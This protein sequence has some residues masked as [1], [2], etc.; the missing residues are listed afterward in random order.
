MAAEEVKADL[1]NWRSH[2]Y[3]E[4]G[5]A[6]VDKILLTETI[7]KASQ[8]SQT[9]EQGSKNLDSFSL[10]TRDGRTLNITGFLVESH[11]DGFMVLH[12][13]K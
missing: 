2:P 7:K 11:T 8:P 6:N 4:W 12:N 5:F 1:S 3:S 13:G 10:K 9:F